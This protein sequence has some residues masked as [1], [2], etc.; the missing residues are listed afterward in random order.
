MPSLSFTET[1]GAIPISIIKGGKYNKK[2]L[3]LN[4]E[5]NKDEPIG[6]KEINALTYEKEFKSL[7]IKPQ[8]RIKLI[9]KFNEALHK[10]ANAD[11]LLE[12]EEIKSLYNKI[13]NKEKADKS[14]ILPS[15]S[16]FQLIP[17]NDPNKR[18]VYYI[19]GASGSGKSYIAR[20]LAE[21]YKKF[22]PDR[23]IY[24]ISKLDYDETLDSMKIGK[25]K[26]INVQTLIDD[27]IDMKE[28]TDS[29]IIFDDYDCF[30]GN[31]GKIVQQL[32]DDIAIT[33]RHTNTSMLC[34]THYISNYKKTRLLLN[35]CQYMVLY[36]QATS[37]HQLC[38]LLKNHI[39][40]SKQ[41]CLELK[42]LG[43]WICIAKNYP[44]YLISEH[45][46]KILHTD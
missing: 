2:I 3:F 16:S 8:E 18:Q 22:F 31:T 28:L 32:I 41:D 9:N 40:L 33:G 39:G 34:L 4:A 13:A 14:I 27:P 21:Y 10:N 17:S 15:D 25:P 26:R 29:L 1:E 35:E 20:G 46:A 7:K 24:L 6:K 37:Y 30:E 43:R 44:Q 5:D 19:A 23:E 11:D 38:Y 12:K 36:P 42:K 45:S